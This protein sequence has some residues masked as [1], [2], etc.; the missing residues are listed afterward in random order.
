LADEA[1]LRRVHTKARLNYASVPEYHEIFRR[2]CAE[3][4]LTYDAA[5][6]DELVATLERN[7]RPLRPCDPGEIIQQ[8]R[9][10]AGYEGKSP[11]LDSASVEQACRNYF[12]SA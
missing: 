7:E 1:F 5:V 2:V 8:I 4:G 9:W 10:A 6:V 3:S 12:F 11:S